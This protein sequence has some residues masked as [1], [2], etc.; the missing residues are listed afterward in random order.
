MLPFS[1]PGKKAEMEVGIQEIIRECSWD[2]HLGA[3]KEGLG[4]R[5][6]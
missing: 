5:R 1:P 3:A 4:K 2:Q 6:R